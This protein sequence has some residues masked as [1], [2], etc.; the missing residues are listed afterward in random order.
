M[1]RSIPRLIGLFPKLEGGKHRV[2]SEPEVGISI[3]GEKDHSG[4]DLWGG[5][6]AALFQARMHI[7]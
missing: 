4:R 2:G 1:G 3:K 5:G 6:G 7:C